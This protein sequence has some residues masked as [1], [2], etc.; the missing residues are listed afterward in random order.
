MLPTWHSPLSDIAACVCFRPVNYEKTSVR[1]CLYAIK[2]KVKQLFGGHF[3]EPKV[4]KQPA[5]L[6]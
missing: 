3:F 6:L 1:L 5:L 4:V 2:R